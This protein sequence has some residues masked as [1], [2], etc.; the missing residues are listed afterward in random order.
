MTSWA[1]YDRMSD[2]LGRGSNRVAPVD[3]VGWY[4]Q[5][6][7]LPVARNLNTRGRMRLCSTWP[8]RSGTLIPPVGGDT[9]TKIPIPDAAQRPPAMTLRLSRGRFCERPSRP[10]RGPR[11]RPAAGLGPAGRT[12][13]RHPWIPNASTVSVILPSHLRL[14][15]SATS[16]PKRRARAW[17]CLAAP[18]WTSDPSA[19]QPSGLAMTCGFRPCF[20]CFPEQEGGVGGGPVDREERGAPAVSGAAP[21][22]QIRSRRGASG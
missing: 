5:A 1:W 8:A 12:R 20:W 14:W 9:A 10:R 16:N 7:D 4:L 6:R 17:V 18:C 11:W 2:C 13:A 15:S 19:K 3:V 22:S 21:A